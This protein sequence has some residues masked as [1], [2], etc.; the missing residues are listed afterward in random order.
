MAISLAS[1]P[2]TVK[3]TRLN[4]SGATADQ[5]ARESLLGRVCESFVVHV[6]EGV[7]L[8]PGGGGD[9]SAAVPQGRGHRAS[10]HRVQ[11]PTTRGILDPDA[12]AAND[13]RQGS[14]ELER[15]HVRSLAL[16]ERLGHPASLTRTRAG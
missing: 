7:R 13:E 9:I 16:D 4:P 14:T 12:L 2:L 11:I 3:R 6:G 5:L 8:G 15:E 1:A 10:A